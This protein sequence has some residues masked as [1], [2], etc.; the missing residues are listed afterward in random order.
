[1]G[2]S[3]RGGTPG[4]PAI[5]VQIRAQKFLDVGDPF[6]E[7]IRGK[8]APVDDIAHS[9]DP[10]A[11]FLQTQAIIRQRV[12]VTSASIPGPRR[13][14]YLAGARML[15]LF[16]VLYLLGNQPLGVGALSYPGTFNICLVADQDAFP[17]INIFAAGL[18]DE[19]HALGEALPVEQPDE[20]RSP[21]V[22][23]QLVTV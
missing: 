19:L 6:R 22:A 2:E 10:V 7:S 14:L 18:R 1:M 21:A 23:P 20:R 16:P 17:D 11:T 13:P 3:D 12:N 15:E 9:D 8:S 4:T 5:R